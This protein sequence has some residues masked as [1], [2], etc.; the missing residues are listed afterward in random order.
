L[1]RGVGGLG[2]YAQGDVE[3]GLNGDGTQRDA[4]EM[5]AL[6][7]GAEWGLLADA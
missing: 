1:T 6:M 2:G 3:W 4:R 7:R 5:S